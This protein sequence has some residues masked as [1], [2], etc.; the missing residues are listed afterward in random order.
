MSNLPP[1]SPGNSLGTR[2]HRGV[3]ILIFGIL[4]LV[5][6]APLG[7]FAWIM[8]NA[9]M[10]AMDSGQMDPEGR[11]LTQ[12]GKILG[13]IGTV[14]LAFS[15]LLFVLW[16]VFALVIGVSAAANGAMVFI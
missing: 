2:P 15:L 13:I 7:I 8:G 11:S 14:F 10:K 12:V 9:D 3:M 4:S 16:V 1:M 6:C 5:V